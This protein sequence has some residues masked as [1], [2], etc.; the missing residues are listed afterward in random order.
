MAGERMD[1]VKRSVYQLHIAMDRSSTER[2]LELTWFAGYPM[3][4]STVL[5]VFNG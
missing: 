5:V 1:T 4:E 2:G 3:W